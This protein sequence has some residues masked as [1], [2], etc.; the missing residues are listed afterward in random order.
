MANEKEPKE[1]EKI[2]ELEALKLPPEHKTT[3]F[4]W[5]QE[6]IKDLE[7]FLKDFLGQ[8][9]ADARAVKAMIEISVI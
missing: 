2:E 6:I 5:T 7:G 1:G 3:G 9:L 4:V 8:N